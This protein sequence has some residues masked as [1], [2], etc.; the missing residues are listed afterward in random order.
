MDD[1]ELDN[2][3]WVNGTPSSYLGDPRFKSQLGEDC[4]D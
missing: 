3:T 1:V 2:A 4:C